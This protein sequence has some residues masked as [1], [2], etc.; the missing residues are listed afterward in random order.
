MG[1]ICESEGMAKEYAPFFLDLYETKNGE[2]KSVKNALENLVKDAADFKAENDQQE[3]LLGYK[4]DPFPDKE[5]VLEFTTEAEKII[6]ENVTRDDT[7]DVT[8]KAI[9]MLMA[10]EL[11]FCILTEKGNNALDSLELLRGYNKVR[12]GTKL[13]SNEN[14]NRLN[15][16][17]SP[18]FYNIESL[19]KAKKLG[20][21]TWVDLDPSFEPA[22]ARK[23]VRELYKEIDQWKLNG[24]KFEIKPASK[25]D[26]KKFEENANGLLDSLGIGSPWTEGDISTRTGNRNILVIAPHGHKRDDTGTYQLARQIADELDCYAVVNEKYRKPGN[27]KSD[28]K[29][30]EKYLVDL[31]LWPEIKKST[32]ALKDFIGPIKE[33]KEQ[34]L[35]KDDS[36]FILHIHGIGDVNR[37]KVAELLSEFKD[38]PE[39]LHLL[40]GYGQHR[41]DKTDKKRRTADLSDVV[42]PLIEDLGKQGINAGK[43]PTE[44]ITIK[45]GKKIEKRWYCGNH[46]NR[47]NQELCRPK[48]KIQS[49]QLEFK[50]GG[51]RDKKSIKEAALKLANAVR[52]VWNKETPEENQ[53]LPVPAI[54][55]PNLDKVYT[56]LM[57]I[58]S[59]GFEN[60][61]LDAGRYLINTFY[62]GDPR[63]AHEDKKKQSLNSLNKHIIKLR[64]KN[65][66]APKKSWI[67]NAV[68][69]KIERETIK[70]HSDELFHTYGKLLLSHKVLLLP[71][72]D[73]STKQR[74]IEYAGENQPTIVEFREKIA[75][76]KSSTVDSEAANKSFLDRFTKASESLSQNVSKA[77]EKI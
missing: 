25:S 72:E 75:G 39:D 58:V 73:M 53:N 45:I 9:E 26:W 33:F 68:N 1:I 21:K 37:G 56:K 40:I 35:K 64:E 67:Y 11:R 5:V 76:S 61:M 29:Y 27:V 32:N 66:D 46:P 13:S 62:G 10:N 8:R 4:S 70:A 20:I 65:P 17:D 43:A 24:T 31:Y 30:E 28:E 22:L 59:E 16:K 60:T 7:E 44:H 18:L 15:L 2:A 48:N 57:A 69:L 14:G 49:L 71:V 41:T 6:K 63:V 54:S 12:Y 74:F 23:L 47:L 55:K 34:I 3:I 19:K 77:F 51:F 38:R 36:L 52:V 42:N 50:D